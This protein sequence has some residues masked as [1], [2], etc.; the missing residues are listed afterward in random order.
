ML[1]SNAHVDVKLRDFLCTSAAQTHLLIEGDALEVLR[2]FPAH[3]VDM[4]LTSPP[5]WQQREYAHTDSAG[6]EL[7]FSAYL[8]AL[9][10][11]FGEVKRILKPE[12][13]LWLNLGDVYDNKNLCGI[14]WRVAIAMQD[15]QNWILRNEVIWNKV[16]GSPDNAKDKLRNLHETVFHFVKQKN[17]YYDV[18]AVRNNPGTSSIR[19]GSVV[20]AT[21]VSGVNYRRQIQRST[22]LTDAQKTEALNAL[23]ATLQKVATGELFDFRM[24]IGGQQRTTHSGSTKVSGRASE[25]EAKGYYILPYDKRGSKPGD[26]WDIIPEDEWRK[27]AHYAPFPEELCIMPIKLTCPEDG[28]V[29]DP[30]AGTGTSVVTAVNLKRRGIGID[31]SGEYLQVAQQRL[32]DRQPLLL[33]EEKAVYGVP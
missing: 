28:I 5:Y 2:R 33:L 10:L 32:T 26:V 9:L 20:T 30:F 8:D 16:K 4:V 24:V 29:L 17:Y 14:P 27:D 15:R 12:G 18:D 6:S 1:V 13:S 25:L 11:V 22:M 21:G 19:N 7:T 23:E 3:S 31:I